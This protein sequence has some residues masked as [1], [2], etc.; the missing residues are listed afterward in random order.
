M[1]KTESTC[2]EIARNVQRARSD[3]IGR[4][5]IIGAEGPGTRSS[6]AATVAREMGHE[7]RARL[8]CRVHEMHIVRRAAWR[9]DGQEY[10][11]GGAFD[12][13]DRMH[14]VTQE[15]HHLARAKP[16]RRLVGQAE[17]GLAIQEQEV[18]VA[19]HVKMPRQWPIQT[20]DTGTCRFT[21]RQIGI[22]NH[23]IRSV[24]KSR[25]DFVKIEEIMNVVA[26]DY[27]PDLHLH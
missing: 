19:I 17:I 13:P 5:P 8:I 12:R 7:A 3:A 18:L 6:P 4:L 22:D 20:K 2:T 16:A 15:H 26:H 10:R 11:G 25:L 9:V 24:G 27:V 23:G 14:D 1:T 21:V